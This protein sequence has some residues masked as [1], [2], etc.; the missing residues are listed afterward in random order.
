MNKILFRY[1]LSGFLKNI[2]IVFL[3]FYSFGLILNLFEE[4]EFFKNLDTSIII[5]LTLTALYVPS[6]FITLLPFIIFVSSM[7]FLLNLR[8]NKDLLI[9]KIYGYSNFKIFSILAL[10]S[11]LF[12]WLILLSINPITATMAKYYEKTKSEYSKDTDHLVSVTRNG[13]WI[14]ETLDTG[15][16]VISANKMRLNKVEKLLI[17]DLDN[18]NNLIK[19]ITAD[20]AD[21][22]NNQWILRNVIINDF[23]K[24]INNQENITEYEILS[25]YN[26]DKITSLF[27]NFDTISFL[28]LILNYEKLREKG[29]SKSLLDQNL[30]SML[31]LPF[32]LFI[33]TALASILTMNTLKKSNNFIFIV[34]GIITCVAIY[35]FKDLS[36]ALGQ[37]N[38]VS[39]PVAAWIPVIVVGLFSSIGILQ[40]NEK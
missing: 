35:Y 15:Y 6:M 26:Y 36:M 8:N 10:S 5:P 21:I 19:K 39:L 12:G 34:V 22:S 4:I 13:L 28:D 16:R 33:M 7:W 17:F 24:G 25:N 9:L 2:L 38:R 11:F 3:I 30:N 40:I 1:L 18:Q 29:Y 37:T 23:T 14:K 32:F 27:K 31:S 20:H